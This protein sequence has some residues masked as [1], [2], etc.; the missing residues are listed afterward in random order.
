M[1]VIRNDILVGIIF[2][3]GIIQIPFIVTII[4]KL[5]SFNLGV[6]NKFI[7]ISNLLILIVGFFHTVGILYIALTVFNNQNFNR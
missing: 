7:I 3:Y 5:F 6:I 2:Y 1:I 4:E